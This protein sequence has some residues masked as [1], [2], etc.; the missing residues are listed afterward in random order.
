MVAGW[1]PILKARFSK[2]SG[3]SVRLNVA[4]ETNVIFSGFCLEQGSSRA[5]SAMV[6]FDLSTHN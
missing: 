1:Y 4:M 2:L 5:G 3:S 6:T